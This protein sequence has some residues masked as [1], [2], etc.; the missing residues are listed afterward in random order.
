M[1][2]TVEAAAFS[3]RQ[4]VARTDRMGTA[5]RCGEQFEGI[6]YRLAQIKV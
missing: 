1:E 4:A 2:R 5:S 3:V 6:L